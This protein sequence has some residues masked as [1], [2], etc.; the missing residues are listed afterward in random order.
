MPWFPETWELDLLKIMPGLRTEGQRLS[1]RRFE[2][3]AEAPK[4]QG[5]IGEWGRMLRRKLGGGEEL[6]YQA[7]DWLMKTMAKACTRPSVTAVH[8]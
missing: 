7:N 3:L 8:S 4:I 5:R 6:S 2:P 1:R